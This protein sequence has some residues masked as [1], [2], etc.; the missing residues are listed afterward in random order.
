[1]DRLWCYNKDQI[2]S[3]WWS[4]WTTYTIITLSMRHM[5]LWCVPDKSSTELLEE[6]T[7]PISHTSICSQ[8]LG[9]VGLCIA[10]HQCRGQVLHLQNEARDECMSS[11]LG[12]PT[13][14]LQQS[15]TSSTVQGSAWVPSQVKP[16]YPPSQEHGPQTRRCSHCHGALLRPVSVKS[17]RG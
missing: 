14:G 7:E 5:P 16:P 8:W 9:C 15:C 6:V 2:K 1:M 4:L 11:G 10:Q 17:G 12:A 13:L 3:T